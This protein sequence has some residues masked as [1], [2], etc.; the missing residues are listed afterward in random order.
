LR[1]LAKE[2][3]DLIITVDCGVRS[4]HEVDCGNRLGLD[5]IVTDHHSVGGELPPALAVVNPKRDDSRYRFRNLAGVGVA[6]RLAQGV[7]RAEKQEWRRKRVGIALEEEELLDLVALGTVADVVPLQGENR[8]LVRQGLERLN[9]PQRE[10]IKALLEQAG[11]RP[12]AVTSTAIGFILGPRI[13]AAGRLRSAMLSYRLLTSQDADE[14]K[15]LAAQLGVLNQER[16]KRTSMALEEATRRILAAGETDAYLHFVEGEGDIF[17]PG[18]VGL[19]ANRLVEQFYRPAL[20]IKRGSQRSHGSARSIEEFHITRALDQCSDLLVR[21]GGHAAAAGF[22]VEN[23]NLS[24]LKE[25]LRAIA[26]QKLAPLELVP[27]LQIDA[28]VRLSEL[29]WSLLSWLQRLE[30]CGEGNPPHLF[31]A[32]GVIVREARAV[33]SDGKHLKLWLSDPD[34]GVSWSA[35]AFRQAHWIGHLPDRIDIAFRLEENEW[36]DSRRLQLNVVDMRPT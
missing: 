36:N 33:G 9:D 34:G 11:L 13:N 30:P 18:I 28:E 6:Y 2:K 20:V 5:I 8:F 35:I 7:L 31:V 16:Q 12:G 3:F 4:V 1:K 19:V 29:D 10:G 15:A 24:E 26:T 23:E 32:R 22:T 27:T 21:H 25:R 17:H 14:A